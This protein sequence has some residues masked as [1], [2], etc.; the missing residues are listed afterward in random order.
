LGIV[1]G[2]AYFAVC[3]RDAAVHAVLNLTSHRFSYNPTLYEDEYSSAYELTYN[4]NN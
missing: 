4:Y 2:N 1:S 3:R